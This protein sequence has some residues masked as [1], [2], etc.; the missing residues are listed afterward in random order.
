MMIPKFRQTLQDWIT[1]QWVILT[2]KRIDET[3]YD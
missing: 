3:S 1:Q 2:G